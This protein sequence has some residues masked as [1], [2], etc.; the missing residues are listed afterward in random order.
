MKLLPVLWCLVLANTVEARLGE[1]L[2][3]CEK[4]YGQAKEG[5]YGEKEFAKDGISVNA[6]FGK[7]G[8]CDYI[9]FTAYDQQKRRMLT[10]QEI[11]DLLKANSQGRAMISMTPAGEGK[12]WHDGPGE[13]FAMLPPSGSRMVFYTKAGKAP[14]D[15]RTEATNKEAV[16]AK[17]D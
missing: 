5:K 14:L 6:H 15:A 3:E 12:A 4:R 8:K 16:P 17:K 10:D 7:D 1:T 11:E 9:F 2:T 13:T